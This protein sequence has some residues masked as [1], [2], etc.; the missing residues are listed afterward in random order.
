MDQAQADRLARDMVKNFGRAEAFSGYCF[1]YVT[2]KYSSSL[3]AFSGA[4]SLKVSGRFH[5][6][7]NFVIVYTSTELKTA[8]WEYFHTARS[9]GIDTTFLLPCTVISATVKL[10]RVLN[11]TDAKVRR[12][13]KVTL[14]ELCGSTWDGSLKETLTQ[15]IG[16]FAYEAGFEAVL[17]PSVGGGQNL[18]I[19]RQNLLAASSLEIINADKLPC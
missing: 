3:D 2:P 16:R 9:A 6:K 13:L 4:G 15:A 10:S 1:R 18:N 12:V 14:K 19:F 8:E 17:V 7:G 5:V 11:L